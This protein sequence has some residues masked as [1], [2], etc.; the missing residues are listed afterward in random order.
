MKTLGKVL[1]KILCELYFYV[2][3]L[4]TE[5]IHF[6]NA[7]IYVLKQVFTPR[8]TSLKGSQTYYLLFIMIHL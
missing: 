5:A 7:P 2:D 4:F 1:R 8:R 6:L 3:I